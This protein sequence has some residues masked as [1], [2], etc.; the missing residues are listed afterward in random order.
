MPNHGERVMASTAWIRSLALLALFFSLSDCAALGHF[1]LGDPAGNYS[2]VLLSSVH[3]TIFLPAS[4]H[5]KA[6]GETD[7][8]EFTAL[9]TALVPV[10]TAFAFG[11]EAPYHMKRVTV[12]QGSPHADVEGWGDLSLVGRYTFTAHRESSFPL[13]RLIPKGRISLVAKVTPPT[14]EHSRADP[15][16]D[17]LP[18]DLQLG[19]GSTATTLGVA[20]MTETERL[21]MVHGHLSYRLPNS[22]GPVRDGGGLDCELRPVLAR[23]S[24]GCLYPSL[25]LSGTWSPAAKVDHAGHGAGAASVLFLSPGIQTPW[26]Y[27][28]AAGMFFMMESAGFLPVV[29]QQGEMDGRYSYALAGGLRVYSR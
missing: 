12:I 4:G 14:A 25:G 8:S 23:Y 11:L 17:P 28:D 13:R 26:W 15:H 24:V 22:A 29:Q 7:L 18:H 21:F 20:F 9:A 6:A 16:G 1:H 2:S 10:G 5:S 27:W 3:R 19:S